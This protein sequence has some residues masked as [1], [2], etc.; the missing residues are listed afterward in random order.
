MTTK[1]QLIQKIKNHDATI[2]IIGLGYVG[3]PIALRFKDIFSHVIGFDIDDNKIVSIQN[4][5]SYIQQIPDSKIKWALNNNLNVTS[6][7]TQIHQ[8]DCIII[9]V[10][11]PLTTHFEPDLK[12]VRTTMET[13]QP[14]LRKGQCLSLESTTFPGTTEEILKPRIEKN[15]LT[16]GADFFLVFSPERE[17]PGNEE[18]ST[19]SIP[20]VVGGITR[21][22]LDVG[23]SL[24]NA[25]IDEIVP[26]SDTKT[27]EMTKL[28]ENIHRAVNIGLVNEMK[29]VADKMGINIHEVIEAAA[30]KPFGFTRYN[31]G[32]GL[33]GHC[34]PI[35]PYYLT[36]KAK[37]FGLN[38]RFIELSGEINR[39]MP[40]W[41]INKL[42]T[43][44][45][46]YKKINVFS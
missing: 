29:M 12:F 38:T 18:F 11:T 28:L 8:C 36:W 19:K 22:C 16:I 34:I 15:A 44:L 42:S 4:G 21:D 24:Y 37:E 1:S 17:D 2:G 39:F 5:Q 43:A 13:I 3:L 27:A 45:N 46:T 26:V 40:T 25:I 30:T 35:D 10:P 6:D 33:G 7:F 32:P 41:V 9:C 20:K 23:M 14:Y 31:P